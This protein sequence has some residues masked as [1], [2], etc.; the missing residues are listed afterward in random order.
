MLL[1]VAELGG[2]GGT[3]FVVTQ[4]LCPLLSWLLLQLQ[5]RV[6]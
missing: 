3:V 4:P 5:G 2:R 1:L 6:E